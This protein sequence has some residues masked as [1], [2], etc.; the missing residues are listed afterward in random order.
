MGPSRLKM[1]ARTNMTGL[2]YC[3]NDGDEG[4]GQ[5]WRDVASLHT[6]DE[7][8][9]FAH[10]HL[11]LDFPCEYH[12]TRRIF[13]KLIMCEYLIHYNNILP[14]RS[15]TLILASFSPWNIRMKDVASFELILLLACDV[16][17][18]E[19]NVTRAAD[20]IGLAGSP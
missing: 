4:A 12:S 18:T 15:E 7:S 6:R 13:F 11:R 10:F 16:S 2:R 1:V 8:I 5:H 3:T 14:E 9:L 19:G 20:R 17:M